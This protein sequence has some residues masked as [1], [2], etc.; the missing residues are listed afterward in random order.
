M[1][2]TR[3]QILQM[4]ASARV[5][6][7]RYDNAFQSWGVRAKGPVLGEDIDSY[8]RD[9]AVQAKKLLPDDHKYRKVQYRSMRA[10]AFEVMEPELLKAVSEAGRRNDSVRLVAPLREVH[11]R[12]PNG[13]HVIKFLGQRSFVE[14]FKSIPRRVAWFNT[15]YGRQTTNGR[16]L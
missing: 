14:Q 10:D 1:P 16:Y 6:Q 7:E 11:E 8:R 13:E 9:L 15:P 4:N 12:G 3:D 2:M 5:Y